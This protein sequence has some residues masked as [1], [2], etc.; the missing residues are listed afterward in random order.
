MRNPAKRKASRA[1]YYAR[2][3]ERL[4][5]K[6]KAYRIAHHEAIL[7]QKTRYRAE[8]HEKV[9]EGLRQ[10]Y[11]KFK[12]QR[13]AE[14]REWAKAHPEKIKA[15][16]TA[17]MRANRSKHCQVEAKRR[18]QK[19]GVPALEADKIAAWMESWRERASVVCYW[20]N[21]KFPGASC[22]ADH[23]T[24]L[25]TGGHHKLKN[26]CVSCS[27]CNFSKNAKSPEVWNLSLQ[28]PRL[29]L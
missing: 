25:G 10:S 12:S 4:R 29:F 6:Q 18:A 8:H 24:P 3:R 7:A 11:V 20:C 19:I 15:W 2:N 21:G 28:Q 16:K 22:H 14:S 9:K 23:I 1:A 13:L 26:L 27:N 5:T 17:W